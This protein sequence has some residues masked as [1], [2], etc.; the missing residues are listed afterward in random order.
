[1]TSFDLSRITQE[2][3]VNHVEYHETLDSTNKLAAELLPDLLPLRP[4][5]VLTASQT[6]GRG[7]GTNAWWAKSGALTFSLVVNANYLELPPERLPLIS[8]AVGLAVKNTIAEMLPQRQVSIKWPNDV[9]INERKVCG[10]LV[11]QRISANQAALI[12]GIGVNV[13]NSMTSA[14]EDMSRRATSIFDV[15]GDTHDMTT[16]LISLL[17]Q[18]DKAVSDLRHRPMM[19]LAQLNACNILNGRTITISLSGSEQTGECKGVDEDGA[20]VLATDHGIQRVLAG[21]VSKW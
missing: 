21:T 11:E 2:T 6:A 16:V 5:L 20:I 14:P 9:L 4:A 17:S 1:M 8:L 10:I 18:L 12:I 3:S 7:R 13:N 15:S 19:L